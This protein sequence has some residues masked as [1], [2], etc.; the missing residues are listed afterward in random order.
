MRGIADRGVRRRTA[1]ADSLAAVTASGL[2]TRTRAN[3]AEID[4]RRRDPS[5]LGKHETQ[6][7]QS[8]RRHFLGGSVFFRGTPGTRIRGFA[9]S[10]A[11]FADQ[12]P[13]VGRT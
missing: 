3:K 10:R 13:G 4:P 7:I 6:P 11:E 8:C 2:A 12:G 5:R 9:R 1:S